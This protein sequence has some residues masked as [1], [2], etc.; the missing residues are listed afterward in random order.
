MQRGSVWDQASILWSTRRRVLSQ[1]GLAVSADDMQTEGKQRHQEVILLWL[2][3]NA[4]NRQRLILNDT[5]VLVDIQL[6][7]NHMLF[8][9]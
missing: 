8:L 3:R 6:K 4:A 2:H 1:K 5:F 7:H 9:D